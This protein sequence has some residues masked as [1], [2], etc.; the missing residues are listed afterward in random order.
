MDEGWIKGSVFEKF[1]HLVIAGWNPEA[2]GFLWD[3]R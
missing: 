1:G 2:N 3:R